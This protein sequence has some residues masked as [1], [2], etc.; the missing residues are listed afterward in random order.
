MKVIFI[1]FFTIVLL[2]YPTA[3][4]G[5]RHNLLARSVNDDLIGRMKLTPIT[6][7][8][9]QDFF[10]NEIF[11]PISI[12]YTRDFSSVL[13]Y[14][15]SKSRPHCLDRLLNKTTGNLLTSLVV[16]CNITRPIRTRNAAVNGFYLVF[17]VVEGKN[18]DN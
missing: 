6:F 1:I 7:T 16:Q 15:S 4:I 11:W 5:W 14:C 10:I 18:T 13:K 2:K 17:A 3:V 9:W 8:V 12:Q